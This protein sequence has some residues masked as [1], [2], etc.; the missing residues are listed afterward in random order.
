MNDQKRKKEKIKGDNRFDEHPFNLIEFNFAWCYLF[1]AF[2]FFYSIYLFFNNRK[3]NP[4]PRE[5]LWP[6]QKRE[7]D[8]ERKITEKKGR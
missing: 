6:G 5:I 4:R 7:E 1:L 3:Y 8:E 2:F